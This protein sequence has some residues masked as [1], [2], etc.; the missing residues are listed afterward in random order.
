MGPGGCGEQLE[1]GILRENCHVGLGSSGR[2]SDTWSVEEHLSVC[3]W[4]RMELL[5]SNVF[6]FDVYACLSFS[7]KNLFLY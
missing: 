4:L 5:F 1:E 3:L 7:F 2:E 6:V